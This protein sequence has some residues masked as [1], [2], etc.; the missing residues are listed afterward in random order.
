MAHIDYYLSTYSPSVYLAGVRLEQIAAKNG[1]SIAYKPL[2][3]ITLFGRT[4]GIAPKDRH[5]SRK[6]YRLQEL[7]RQA[8]KAGK[9]IKMQP[10]FW[11]VNG[12]PS[13]YA[14]IAAINAGQGDIGALAHG[15][16]RACWEEDRN[17]AD[18]AV[19]RAVLTENGFDPALADTGLMQAADT[20]TANLEEAVQRGVFGVPF[21]IV[22]GAERFWGQD[23]L[24]DLDAYLAGDL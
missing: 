22:D 14:L 16:A 10:A 17:I 13:A 9:P 5:E 6:E 24:D 3:V 11:P 8:K 2:D 21:Y 20:Y 12:A 19:V 1:A 4:G 18:D 7:R 15:F 23:R